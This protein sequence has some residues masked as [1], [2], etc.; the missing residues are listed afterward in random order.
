MRLLHA[1]AIALAVC[2]P[3]AAQ[4]T[5]REEDALNMGAEAY[6]FGYPA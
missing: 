2:L 3:A 1:L 6:V 4:D 5:R